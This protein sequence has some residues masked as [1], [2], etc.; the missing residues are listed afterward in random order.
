MPRLEYKDDKK[1]KQSIWLFLDQS[2]QL[3]KAPVLHSLCIKLGSQCPVD[4]EVGKWV[5]KAVDRFVR[6][7][8]FKLLWSADPISLPKSLYTCETL[9]KLK[10][11]DKVL[12]DFPSSPAC[13]PSLKKLNLINVV[14]KDDASLIRFLSSCSVIEK[15]R[16]EREGN[17]NIK[18]FNVIVPSLHDLTYTDYNDIYSYVGNSVRFLVIDTP[19]V[20]YI[21][22]TNCSKQYCL[23]KNMPCLDR[24]YI[25]VHTYADDKL[26]RSLSSVLFLELDLADEMLL[27]CSAINFSRLT[28]LIICPDESDWL[29]PLMLLLG[30]SPKLKKLSVD[31]GP[32]ENPEDLPLSWNEPSSVPGCL[33][34]HL[35]IFEWVEKYG[36]RVEEL[37]F[38]TYILANSKCLKRATISLRSAFN[39]EQ[40]QKVMKELDSIPRVSKSSQ[41]LLK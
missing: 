4:V 35:E 20:K 12:T 21:H 13:L 19:A 27:R 31:Y 5:A 22:L 32:T 33:S 6:K 28:E 10:I 41:L 29:E 17:D 7:L 40:K 9:V 26:P 18:N 24:A 23:I 25:S 34:S 16:V 38:V 11:S 2:L 1:S 37:G 36:G 15:L 3:H 14:Y 30:K 8:K 39:L